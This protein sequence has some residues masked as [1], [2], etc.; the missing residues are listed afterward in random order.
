MEA[1]AACREGVGEIPIE[2]HYT[3]GLLVPPSQPQNVVTIQ[4]NTD[5]IWM[6]RGTNYTNQQAQLGGLTDDH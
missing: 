6:E 2:A 3:E 1:T 5:T 4:P